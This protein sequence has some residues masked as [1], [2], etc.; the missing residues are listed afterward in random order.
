MPTSG[1]PIRRA[2]VARLHALCDECPPDQVRTQPSGEFRLENVPEDV[3]PGQ[4][5]EWRVSAAF[6]EIYDT[7]A[8]G[9]DQLSLGLKDIFA[10]LGRRD[11]PSIGS[12][13]EAYALLQK[14]LPAEQQAALKD[15]F[16][17]NTMEVN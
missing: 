1:A 4:R 13:A 9:K 14:G 7:H 5:N 3:C 6:W 17:Q 15:A 2:T 16:V 12:A 10:A 8:D 11:M